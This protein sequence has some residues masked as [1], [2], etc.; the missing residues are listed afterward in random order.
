[1]KLKISSKAVLSLDLSGQASIS[2]WSQ[3]GRI[4][5]ENAAAVSVVTRATVGEAEAETLLVEQTQSVE[6]MLMA[7]ILIDMSGQEPIACLILKQEPTKLRRR[8]RTI[9]QRNHVNVGGASSESFLV[10][11]QFKHGSFLS[12]KADN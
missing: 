4:H 12:K 11:C 5:C 3:T 6:G 7:D 2:L 10:G 9:E 8:E 1:M